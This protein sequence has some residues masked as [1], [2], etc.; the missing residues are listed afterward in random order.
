[1]LTSRVRAHRMFDGLRDKDK[2][3]VVKSGLR[4]DGSAWDLLMTA[5]DKQQLAIAKVINIANKHTY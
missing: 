1:M 4:G 2:R 5:R 3:N